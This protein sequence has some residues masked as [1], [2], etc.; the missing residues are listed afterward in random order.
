MKPTPADSRLRTARVKSRLKLLP[1]RPRRRDARELDMP[2]GTDPI[3][4][5]RAPVRALWFASSV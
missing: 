5:D 2:V 3:R 1:P 4:N